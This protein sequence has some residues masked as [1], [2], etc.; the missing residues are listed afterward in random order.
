HNISM[1]NVPRS[2]TPGSRLFLAF[3]ETDGVAF[4]TPEHIG[5]PIVHEFRSSIPSTIRLTAHYLAVYA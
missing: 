4:C 2:S 1:C 5:L 3:I